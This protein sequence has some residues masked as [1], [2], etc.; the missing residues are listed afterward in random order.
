MKERFFTKHLP[1]QG[2]VK[3]ANHVFYNN[4]IYRV[5]KDVD[6]EIDHAII[7]DE[8]ERED[9]LRIPWHELTSAKL[10]L[11]STEVC[12]KDN[13]RIHYDSGRISSQTHTCARAESMQDRGDMIVYTKN[14]TDYLV[15]EANCI[16]ILGEVL[17]PDVR[18]GL[19]FTEKQS[20]Y[21][22]LKS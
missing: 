20:K 14:G 11:C 2:D 9:Y 3:E 18:G 8:D 4:D 13:F 15:P 10:F 6:N 19:T 22:T 7:V 12:E 21:L 16:K 17:T 5:C 1:V